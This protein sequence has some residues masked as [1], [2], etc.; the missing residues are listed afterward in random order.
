MRL[1][2]VSLVRQLEV[3]A[4]SKV[5]LDVVVSAADLAAVAS[6]NKVVTAVKSTSPTFVHLS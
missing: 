3:V 2:H 4:A 5:H 1:N 6:N